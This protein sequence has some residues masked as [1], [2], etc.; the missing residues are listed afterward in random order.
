MPENN[1]TLT[2]ELTDCDHC[3][4]YAEL[5]RSCTDAGLPFKIWNVGTAAIIK[6]GEGY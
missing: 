4:A 3:K 6:I 1:R 5:V 2:F